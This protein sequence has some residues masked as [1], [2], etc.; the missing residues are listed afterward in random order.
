MRTLKLTFLVLIG[1]MFFTGCKKTYLPEGKYINET[2]IPGDYNLLEVRK[3][4][5]FW[6]MNGKVKSFVYH[7]DG[8]KLMGT[9]LNENE[10][11]KRLYKPSED[12]FYLD[13][14]RFYAC[15]KEYDRIPDGE[16]E[17]YNAI[18]QY[19]IHLVVKGNKIIRTDIRYDEVLSSQ[20]LTYS[21]LPSNRAAILEH[22]GF[23]E[24]LDF[25]TTHDGFM[26][27][28]VRFV[29]KK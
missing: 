25:L 18:P 13:N 15:Q 14:I 26:L 24:K 27:S 10:D 3:D 16:Y 2:A 28:G 11:L 7:I 1:T 29:K 6:E 8:K 22:D 20:D 21:I 17:E 5:L 23:Q 12:G 19:T 9:C 4:T